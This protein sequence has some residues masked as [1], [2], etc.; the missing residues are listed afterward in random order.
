M[1]D[2]WTSAAVVVGVAA[3]A[4]TH[5]QRLDPVIALLAAANFVRIGLGL[6]RRSA[7]ASVSLHSSCGSKQRPSS[8]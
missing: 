6:F 5:I 7:E 2:V 4:V 3:V 8:N 1:A